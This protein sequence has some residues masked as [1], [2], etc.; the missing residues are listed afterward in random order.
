MKKK[1]IL[2]S[3]LMA[4]LLTACGTS[5]PETNTPP[6]TSP[7]TESIIEETSGDST[8]SSESSESEDASDTSTEVETDDLSKDNSE[9]EE[10]PDVDTPAP[11]EESEERI[12]IKN[13]ITE[14][15]NK[16]EH[17]V[18][19]EVTDPT[20]LSEFFLI[21]TS[22][23]AFEEVVVYQCP[24]SAQMSEIIVIKSSDV[25]HAADILNKRRDKAIAQDAFYPA[26]VENAEAS[27]VGTVGSYAYFIINGVAA[28]DEAALTELLS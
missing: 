19:D 6:V 5:S 25:D 20:I 14:V 22:D 12:K 13:A 26:D 15:L 8:E 17:A 1:A 24:M 10:S 3:G 11:V 7:A 16:T 18:M 4:I 28:E 21:D 23:E 27:I 2:I 9:T